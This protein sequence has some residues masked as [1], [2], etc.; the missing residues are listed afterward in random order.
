[1]RVPRDSARCRLVDSWAAI[2][3]E[4][5]AW[6]TT[7]RSATFWWRDDDATRHGTRLSRLLDTART[8][9]LAIAVIP[10][11]AHDELAS[12]FD[13][14]EAFGGRINVVQ[15]GYAHLS[16]APAGERKAEYG[17]H[18]PIDEMIAELVRG[19]QILD[20]MFA[21]RFRPILTPPWNRITPALVPRLADA[22]FAGLSVFGARPAGS[23][24]NV[25][26]THIDIIDWRG[27]R[28]FA[29]AH[30]VLDAAVGH[31]R[32]RRTGR[33]DPSEP[34]GLLTHHRIHDET[35]WRFLDR[36][37]ATVE[38]HPAAEWIDAF[39]WVGSSRQ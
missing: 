10:A 30:A 36:L 31:L 8:T 21:N 4:L 29:G 2:T 34:T 27:S 12:A 35:C 3:Q 25:V 19:R 11:L 33:A 13:N 39:E 26:N 23:P 32:A 17:A 37:I 15:H 9:P 1:M 7:G 6:T 28:A 18:R 14:R 16:H 20:R 5:D 24:S 22:G 38:Q